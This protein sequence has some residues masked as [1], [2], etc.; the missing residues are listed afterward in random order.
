MT[1]TLAAER[2]ELEQDDLPTEPNSPFSGDEAPRTSVSAPKTYNSSRVAQS[3]NAG[4]PRTPVKLRQ[5]PNPRQSLVS[6]S[7]GHNSDDDDDDDDDDDLPS[8]NLSAPLATCTPSKASELVDQIPFRQLADTFY[9]QLPSD[10]SVLYY[11]TN[12]RG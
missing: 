6:S 9:F 7:Y 3:G 8:V 10:D 1:S 2:D 5:S 11:K 12:N 4:L